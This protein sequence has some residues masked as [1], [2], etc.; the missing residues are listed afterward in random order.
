MLDAVSAKAASD[1]YDQ[2][3]GHATI[4]LLA[5]TYPLL[6][7]DRDPANHLGSH[8]LERSLFPG[9][10]TMHLHAC[11]RTLLLVH[12][13]HLCSRVQCQAW[14]QV[15]QN[16]AHNQ[17][18]V[19][20]RA[21]NGLNASVGSDL[22]IGCRFVADIADQTFSFLVARDVTCR[23]VLGNKYQACTRNPSEMRHFPMAINQENEMAL[24]GRC[25]P[26]CA[27]KVMELK[28]VDNNKKRGTSNPI[29]TSVG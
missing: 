14:I 16:V 27:W 4:A 24:D 5:A 28:S 26:C 2:T 22:E 1:P 8:L 29:G 10:R 21:H 12:V 11:S 9:E 13:A 17:E 25:F 7:S 19:Q 18:D 15:P 23:M 20:N 3:L 6:L